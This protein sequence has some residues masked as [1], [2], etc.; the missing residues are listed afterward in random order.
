MHAVSVHRVDFLAMSHPKVSHFLLSSILLFAVAG[1]DRLS[2]NAFTAG[3]TQGDGTFGPF[4]KE[5]GIDGNTEP[6]VFD[7]D[8]PLEGVTSF[9]SGNGYQRGKN[10]KPIR[11]SPVSQNPYVN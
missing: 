5:L 3:R 6:I 4:D 7:Y 10:G 1:C 11:I 2:G 9:E 8:S